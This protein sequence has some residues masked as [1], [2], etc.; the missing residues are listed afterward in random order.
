MTFS[1]AEGGESGGG[2]TCAVPPV[3]TRSGGRAVN[4]GSATGATTGSATG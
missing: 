2:C 4:G 1:Y 3:A